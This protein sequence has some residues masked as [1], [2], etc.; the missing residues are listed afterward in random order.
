MT[1]L[2]YCFRFLFCGALSRLGPFGLGTGVG[3]I[4]TALS[5]AVVD[6]AAADDHGSVR[7]YR[8]NS[9]DQLVKQRWVKDDNQAGCHSLSRKRKAHRFAQVGFAWCSVYLEKGC[10]PG[11][12]APAKWAGGRYRN[13]DI[14]VDGSQTKLL[15]GSKW[16]FHPTEN[17]L[18]ASWAC[19]Y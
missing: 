4:V 17:I 14:N 16:Y 5:L 2:R 11:T 6:L 13:A 8:L 15:R 12:E 19:E 3:I 10:K 1:H 18:I 9:K 7:I